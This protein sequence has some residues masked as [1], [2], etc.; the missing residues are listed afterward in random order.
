MFKEAGKSYGITVN[1]PSWV[2]LMEYSNKEM[3]Y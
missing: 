1:D 2:E 3:S